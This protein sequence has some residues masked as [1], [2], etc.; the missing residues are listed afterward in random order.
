MSTIDGKKWQ[1]DELASDLA[2]HLLGNTARVVWLDMQLGPSGNQRPDVYA[3][4][5]TYTR[6]DARVFEIKV[7]RSDFLSDVTSGKWQGYLR[8]CNAVTFA[9]PEGLVKRDEVPAGCGLMV[10]GENG[11][12]GVKKPTL[13]QLREL[14]TTVWQKLLFDGIERA[15]RPALRQRQGEYFARRRA[16]EVLGKEWEKAVLDRDSAI[17]SLRQETEN[18]RAEKAKTT[19]EIRGVQKR[20]LD[21]VRE[22]LERVK[23]AI[24][25]A[26]KSVGLPETASA[27]EVTSA[28]R[29]MLNPNF[30][31]RANSFLMWSRIHRESMEKDEAELR[32]ILGETP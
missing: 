23:R 13:Q 8:W 9:V 4:E 10:R 3:I 26:A 14:P 32:R 28:I 2:D 1:H 29:A 21:E 20:Q 15:V 30:R 27:Y 25:D 31:E 22:G 12:K 7:S 24:A 18:L 17:Y 5:K 11:W 6:L 19:D 16:F